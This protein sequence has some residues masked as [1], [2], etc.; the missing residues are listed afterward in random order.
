[1][2]MIK[3]ITVKLLSRVQTGT[4]AFN[5]PVYTETE[6]DIDNVLVAPLSTSE[7][8]D[9]LNLTGHKAQY[10]LA[11]PKG[12]THEWENQRVKFFGQTCECSRKNFICFTLARFFDYH[13]RRNRFF[14]RFHITRNFQ[15]P[16]EVIKHDFFYHALSPYRLEQCIVIVIILECFFR[17]CEY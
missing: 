11:I 1:M 5:R 16:V 9:T 8:L 4:D 3:G 12:D 10:Q 14:G 2:A 17:S 13:I 6:I 7:V 15:N